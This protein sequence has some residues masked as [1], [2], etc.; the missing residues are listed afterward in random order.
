ML[1]HH[2]RETKTEGDR[3]KKILQQLLIMITITSLVFTMIGLFILKT[4]EHHKALINLF[5]EVIMLMLCGN[6]IIY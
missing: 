5:G 6:L 2:C 1:S 4:P 3:V